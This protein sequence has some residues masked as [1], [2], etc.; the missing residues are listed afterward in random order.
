[1]T[2]WTRL[3]RDVADFPKP[4]IVFKAITAVLAEAAGFAA[5]IDAMAAPGAGRPS[6]R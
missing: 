2:D 3:I 1:M 4:G 6:T 5:A